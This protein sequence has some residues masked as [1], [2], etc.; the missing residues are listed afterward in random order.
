MVKIQPDGKILIGGF[1]TEVNGFAASGIARVNA[2]GSTD[3]S[4]KAP[5]F[6]GASGIGWQVFAI[7]LQEDG[8]ILVC[9]YFL[10]TDGVFKPGLRR[11]NADGS[12]DTSFNIFEISADS[13]L[14]DIVIL[15]DNKILAH[16]AINWGIRSKAVGRGDRHSN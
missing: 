1:F 15:P 16:A 9:F 2:D 10:A 11:L 8:M 12:L 5:D 7:T 14:Y 6:S 3:A 4:F 13:T